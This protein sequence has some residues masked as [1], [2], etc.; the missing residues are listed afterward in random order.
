MATLNGT[1]GNDTITSTANADILNGLAGNDTLN[2]NAGSDTLNGDAGNDLLSGGDQNDFLYGGTEADTLNGDLGDDLLQGGAG[3]D[4]FDGGDGIDTL[5]YTGSNLAVDVS[6]LNGFAS[7]GHAD[8]DVFTGMENLTGSSFNDNLIGDQ[9]ANIVTGAAGDDTLDGGMGADTLFGGLGNDVYFVDN[10]DDVVSEAAGGGVDYIHSSVSLTLNSDFEI[11]RLIGGQNI[12]GTGN[13]NANFI[14]GNDGSTAATGNNYLSGLGGN[15]TIFGGGGA[16]TLDGG[17]GNDSMTGGDGSDLYVVDS[18]TDVVIEVTGEGEDT[19]EAGI[20]ITLSDPVLT[21][22]VEHVTLTGTGNLFATG[23]VADN[24]LVGNVGNNYLTGNSGDDRLFGDDGNDTLDGGTGNDSMVGGAGNDTY[25][26]DHVSD[27]VIE[28]LNA[29]TDT[30]FTT[31]N[32][33]ELDNYAENLTFGLAVLNGDGNGFANIITANAQANTIDAGAGS[34][35][36]YGGAGADTLDGGSGADLLQ[37]GAGDDTYYVDDAGDVVTEAEVGAN[38]NDRVLTTADHTLGAGIEELVVIGSGADDGTGNELANRLTG[39]TGTNVLSGMAGNDSIFGG[40]GDD[41]LIGG[42]GVDVFDGGAGDD[43]YVLETS[44]ESV[45]ELLGGGI[46]TVQL[47]GSY[48]LSQ[49][50][51]DV[52]LLGTGNHNATG[53]DSANILT[54]NVGANIL[55]GNVGNDSLYGGAGNDSLD[56]GTGNDSMVGGTGDDIYVVDSA[57]DRISEIS[58]GGIDTVQAWTN[59][60]LKSYIERLTLQGSSNLTGTGNSL[61]NVL[62]GNGGNNLLVGDGGNDQINGGAGDDTLNGGSG[63][64]TMAGGVGNDVY[65]I[66]NIADAMTEISGEGTDTVVSTLTHTLGANLENL[67]LAGSS[68]LN[69]T[70]NTG[71][72][73]LVGN[74]GANKLSGLAGADTLEGGAGADTLD[75]GTGIDEMTGGAGND[76]YYIADIGDQAIEAADGGIDTIVS[77]FT[78]TLV[79]PTLEHLTLTGSANLNGTGNALANR[80]TGNLGNNALYGLAG[81]DSLYGGEGSDTL[82]GGANNDYM[83]GG[84]GDDVY[85]VSAATDIISEATVGGTDLV[86]TSANFTMGAG[87]ENLV[88][89]GTAD[90]AVTGSSSANS[91][92]GNAGN[93]LMK[94]GSGAD[95]LAGGNGADTLDGGTGNDTAFGGA[96]DDVYYVGVANDVVSEVGGSGVDTVIAGTTWTLG[97]GFENLSMIGTSSYNGT[98]NVADNVITGNAG[99]NMINGVGGDDTINGGVGNDTLT[100]GTG[101]DHFVFT[102]ATA[103]NDT[104]TDFNAVEGGAAEGDLLVFSDL[105][106]GAFVYLGDAAFTGGSNNS[107]ARYDSTTKKLLIDIDG[108]GAAEFALTLTGMDAATEITGAMFSWS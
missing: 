55:T 30:V 16:D 73:L 22:F 45:T 70:G 29:G 33:Y 105:E 46:D 65:H 66:D 26:I 6:L 49:H 35:T 72:N 52:V 4:S 89:Q 7:G 79:S 2:G 98:G 12:D 69:A 56:G 40:A 58:T 23:N 1:S 91:M 18:A 94:G 67:T 78:T 5:D 21:N 48:T 83:A 31:L 93:N 19:I 25:Y 3:G 43:V 85:F 41:T 47:D 95:T 104:I 53:N 11:L 34:D 42:T 87:L 100:G 51:E 88:M 76:T 44:T 74:A 17:I 97:A 106:V 108:N 20:S 75:G 24:T 27:K 63:N 68:S 50:L 80:L 77:I 28:A 86:Y 62:T 71:A 13:A 84:F 10:L 61:S 57:N 54:G 9:F 59:H 103:G 39:N 37:G 32:N 64:D 96:G 92:T 38:G 102:T 14:Y 60:T 15:D 107:E 8:G 36:V 99:R 90:L 101:A 81:D 82:D